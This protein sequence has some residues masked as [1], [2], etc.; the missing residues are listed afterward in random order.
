MKLLKIKI[1][2]SIYVLFLS[3]LILAWAFAVLYPLFFWYENPQCTQMQI[4]RRFW[5]TY[6]VFLLNLPV[7]F[8]MLY[9]LRKC[10][11]QKNDK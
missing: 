5:K 10:K 6:L 8:H 4:L 11:G 7:I 9:V 3:V 2:L 1:R